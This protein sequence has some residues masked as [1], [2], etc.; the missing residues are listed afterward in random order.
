M[1]NDSETLPNPVVVKNEIK[2]ESTS[3]DLKEM[4]LTRKNLC[5]QWLSDQSL[6]PAP[7]AVEI[8]LS[9]NPKLSCVFD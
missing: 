7:E 1:M 5:E 3:T 6:L 8:D 4:K 2:K 9:D